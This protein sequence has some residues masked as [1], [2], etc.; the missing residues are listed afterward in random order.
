MRRQVMTVAEDRYRKRVSVKG[1]WSRER[2]RIKRRVSEGSQEDR[3][4]VYI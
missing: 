1:V 3:R 4:G 2:E